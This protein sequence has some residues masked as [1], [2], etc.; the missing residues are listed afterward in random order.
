[1][2]ALLDRF[3]R[4]LNCGTQTIVNNDEIYLHG[5]VESLEID[6][7]EQKQIIADF[8][9]KDKEQEIKVVEQEMKIKE[10]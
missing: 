3:K 6:T 4:N 8:V 2:K 7:K 5:R 9:K 10:L 1:M